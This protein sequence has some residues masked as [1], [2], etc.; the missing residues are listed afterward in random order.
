MSG[1]VACSMKKKSANFSVQVDL[2]NYDLMFS[3]AETDEQVVSGLVK[4]G[5]KKDK[6]G[7]I[8]FSTDTSAGC[9]IVTPTGAGMI[10]MR[11]IPKTSFHFGC[12][13]HEIFH[14][15][16]YLMEAVGMP[17]SKEF[18]SEAYAYAIQY[19]TEQ[20]YKKLNKFY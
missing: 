18:S 3:F 14:A 9:Y 17:H 6:I 8:G 2:Y 15:V 19:I 4:R 20:C 10:R 5:Y 7:D 13:A 1:L 12:L 11:D 16:E